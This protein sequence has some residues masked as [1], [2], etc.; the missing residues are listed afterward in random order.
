MGEVYK[1]N[2]AALNFI[3]HFLPVSK[4]QRYGARKIRCFN[5]NQWGHM[6]EA[7]PDKIKP[8]KCS[9]CGVAGHLMDY[10]PRAICLNCGS[11]TS[12][13][14]DD[15]RGCRGSGALLCERCHCRGHKAE[16]CP[17]LWRR[18]YSTVSFF[19]MKPSECN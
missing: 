5:C 12:S 13:F 8:P 16:N 18:F 19:L 9:M 17:E 3:N 14:A 4:L 10:C 1:C 15:C 6:K 7:C 2:K 11:K